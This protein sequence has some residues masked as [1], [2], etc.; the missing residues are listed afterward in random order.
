MTKQELFLLI[1]EFIYNNAKSVKTKYLLIKLN[2]NYHYCYLYKKD[3]DFHFLS[4]LVNK[5]L[6]KI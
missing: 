3:I 1:A 5:L 6:A 2:Y 4:I